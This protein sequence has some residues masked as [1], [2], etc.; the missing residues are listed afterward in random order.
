MP[1][2]GN[3]RFIGGHH[4]E[5]LRCGAEYFPALL[6]AIGEARREI[7]LESYIFADDAVGCSV[8]DALCAAARR[9]VAVRVLVDGFGARHFPEKFGARFLESGARYLVYRAEIARFSL[10]RYRLRRLHRK[11]VALDGRVAFIGGI[12]IIDDDNTPPGMGA[13]FDY[14]ARVEGPILAHILAAMR[15]TWEAV[16]LAS[17]QRRLRLPGF[18]WAESVAPTPE[19][20]QGQKVMFLPR[21]NFYRRG[22]IPNAY[23]D[24]LRWA[25]RS[26]TLANAYFLPGWRFRNALLAAARRGVRVTL[27]VQGKSDHPLLHYATEALYDH[28]IAAGI[29]V[30][31][32]RSGFLHAKVAVVDERWATVGSSNIDPLSLFM[33]KESN[34]AVLDE[35]FARQLSESLCLA[36]RHDTTERAFGRQSFFSRCAGWLCY[37]LARLLADLI[38][39]GHWHNSA[40]KAPRV[41]SEPER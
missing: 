37:G 28:L 14:A 32:Y 40:A 34:I 25:K 11:L 13:R 24:A 10:H 23:L 18:S 30:F 20:A 3:D 9:G 31:Y 6:R 36:I 41:A 5:L 27:L 4:V 19:S 16:A 15:R 39:Y 29:R 1:R 17:F 7:F 38:G 8:A 12:N 33:A 22:S 2:A 26:V 35:A 21:N